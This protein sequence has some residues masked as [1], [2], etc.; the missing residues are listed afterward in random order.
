MSGY[1]VQTLSGRTRFAPSEWDRFVD[2]SPQGTI[3][4]RSWWLEAV[5]PKEF[6]ILILRKAGRIVAGMPLVR[7]RR[8]AYEAIG[9]PPLT[10]T[11]GLLLEPSSAQKY[12]GRLSAEMDLLRETV[13]VIPSVAHFTVNFHHTLTNWLPFY[14]AG[15][16][17]TT[18]Y[19][20]VIE[21]TSNLD[22]IRAGMA[23]RCRNALGK[24][25]KEG[26]RVTPSDDIEL[27]LD[28][29]R[30]TFARQGMRL[31]Y[32]ETLVV[33]LDA[34]CA[35]HHSRSIFVARDSLGRVHAA[36]YVVYDGKCMYGLMSGGD[37]VLRASG[38]K[39]LATW[40]AIEVAHE[41]GI[42]Y[43]FEGSMIEN[44][45]R[46][47]RSFGARQVPYFQIVKDSRGAVVRCLLG[48]RSG[49]RRVA[50][51]LGLGDSR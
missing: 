22:Q 29:N 4:C 36:F 41:L 6:E 19:T 40:R 45:E 8:L 44:V 50:C 37:P 18:R 24:A 46:F 12:E 26:I 25:E 21:D 42:P 7:R 11:L 48:L 32:S 28:M 43:D 16:S 51:T 14:W 39:V 31:P 9:M 33:R 38:A 5:C 1:E 17:Q 35:A 30:K 3:F 27:F 20:Y 13:R 34:A 2:D 15:Y 49:A 10:Q 47:V 23:N